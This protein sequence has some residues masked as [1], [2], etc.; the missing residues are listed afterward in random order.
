MADVIPNSQRAAAAADAIAAYAGASEPRHVQDRLARLLCDLRHYADRLKGLRFD[1]LLDHARQ[2]YERQH[3]SPAR[4]TA[5]ARAV[6]V[7]EHHVLRPRQD[8]ARPPDTLAGP[9]HRATAHEVNVEEAP[10][11]LS[12]GLITDLWH[13]ADDHGVDFVQALSASER[14]YTEQRLQEE[15]AFQAGCHTYPGAFLDASP[16][17]PPFQTVATRQGVVTSMNDAEWLLV[18]TAARLHHLERKGHATLALPGDVGDR[19]ALSEALA[20][21][22]GL[23]P[24]EILRQLAPRITERAEII[25]HAAADAAEMGH[26]HGVAGVAPY[27]RLDQDGQD[28]RLMDAFGETEPTTDANAMHR[29]ALV[30]AYATAYRDAR[31]Q[32]G[33]TPTQLAERDYPQE[34]GEPTGRNVPPPSA[35]TERATSHAEVRR[36]RKRP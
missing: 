35:A 2:N 36:P 26:E 32:T 34:P 23:T 20:D 1:E 25:E 24:P 31:K 3:P 10:A 21:A 33:A 14:S 12:A 9:H 11:S 19:R 8:D 18:R 28:S 5:A 29:L 17:A 16:A 30:Q 22:C 7:H 6:E 4:E 13:Y 15:G 27:C